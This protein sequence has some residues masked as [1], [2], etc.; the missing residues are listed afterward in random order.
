MH[1]NSGPSAVA[2]VLYEMLGRRRTY[3]VDTTASCVHTYAGTS[4]PRFNAVQQ[5]AENIAALMR[6]G[7][8]LATGPAALHGDQFPHSGE[9]HKTMNRLKVTR[10]I[11]LTYSR[12]LAVNRR[13]SRLV[14]L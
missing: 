6:S 13:Q 10:P 3:P 5:N 2:T 1:A 8:S 4:A 9:N 7:A 14:A 12:S 11:D